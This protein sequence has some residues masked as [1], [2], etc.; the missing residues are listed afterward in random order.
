[1]QHLQQSTKKNR[2][3]HTTFKIYRKCFEF[4]ACI[5]SLIFDRL[6]SFAIFLNII[7]KNIL[8]SHAPFN[9]KILSS[10]PGADKR[11]KLSKLI[12]KALSHKWEQFHS[13]MTS[14]GVPANFLIFT[15]KIIFKSCTPS[16]KTFLASTLAQVM[17]QN[18]QNWPKKHLAQR[19]QSD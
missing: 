11:V 16:S 14:V 15:G 9:L 19:V 17:S 1:M 12:D 6:G 3:T 7:R 5:V 18:F 2:Q 13:F 4:N 8:S 10:Y